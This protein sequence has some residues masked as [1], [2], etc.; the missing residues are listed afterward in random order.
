L[1]WKFQ[2]HSHNDFQ[3]N[4]HTIMEP[5]TMKL[6]PVVVTEVKTDFN[7]DDVSAWRGRDLSCSRRTF[8]MFWSLGHGSFSAHAPSIPFSPINITLQYLYPPEYEGHFDGLVISHADIIAR[9]AELAALINHKYIGRRPVLVCTLKGAC[10]FFT[11][12]MDALQNLRQGFDVEFVRAKSYHGTSST[13]TVQLLLEKDVVLEHLKGR[14]LLLIEDILDTG[15]TLQKLVPALQEQGHPA[16]VEVV[17]L[18]DK[19]LGDE[20]DK[21]YKAEYIG[22]SIP[23]VFIIGYGL[24]YNEL[25]RDLRDIFVISKAGIAFDATHL[26]A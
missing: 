7:T 5:E 4:D 14:H 22:F 10:T 9:V 19:R 1:D 12:L 11:H 6:E 2:Q 25:Y 24:D 26:H 8:G 23:D 17:T 20:V 18:L 3:V 13:G 15:A 21:K 16:S